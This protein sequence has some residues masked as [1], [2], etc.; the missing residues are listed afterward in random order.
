MLNCWFFTFNSLL[1]KN[2]INVNWNI[3][4]LL[5]DP[6]RYRN[7]WG[8]DIACF[9]INNGIVMQKFENKLCVKSVRIWNYSG[10]YFSAL[11]LNT[12]RYSVFPCIQSKCGKIRTR[13]TLNVNTFTQW[14]I[15][16]I[17]FFFTFFLWEKQS[18]SKVNTR[19]SLNVVDDGWFFIFW[20]YSK[21]KMYKRGIGSQFLTFFNHSLE[22]QVLGDEVLW[23]CMIENKETFFAMIKIRLNEFV[24]Q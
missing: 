21:K 15:R 3:L 13:K 11:G 14:K 22:E 8:I 10:P 23:A 12:E 19:I 1:Q 9:I 5:R 24:S 16:L 17:K 18:V 20:D 2:S 7:R 4:Y 6:F